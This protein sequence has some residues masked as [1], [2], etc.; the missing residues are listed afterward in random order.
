MSLVSAIRHSFV[1]D[2]KGGYPVE[3]VTALGVVWNRY[4]EA[5]R[6]SERAYFSNFQLGRLHRAVW[7]FF[8]G[9]I[10]AGHHVHHKNNDPG[11]NRIE[12][13]EL[14]STKDH[15]G[16]HMREYFSD[17]ENYV[18]ACENLE[19]IR[20]LAGKWH[21]SKEGREWHRQ[22]GRKFCAARSD[23]ECVCKQCGNAYTAPAGVGKGY[24]NKFCSDACKSAARYASGVDNVR[25]KCERC[26][27]SFVANKY[28]RQRFCSRSC[29][30]QR[31]GGKDGGV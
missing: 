28:S 13:L 4:P 6:R 11:D 17:E 9:D 23:L 22:H 31:Q 15:I 18:R 2:P 24:Q 10:P 5:P 1:L 27:K 20:F 7:Q 16:Q 19:A 29:S 21:A 3:S 12:N 25:R 30:S 8:R 26:R 14:L